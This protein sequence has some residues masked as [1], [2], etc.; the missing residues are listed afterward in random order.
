MTK[1]Q[2]DSE[3]GNPRHPSQRHPD[4]GGHPPVQPGQRGRRGRCAGRFVP[5]SVGGHPLLESEPPPDDRAAAVFRFSPGA[6]LPEVRCGPSPARRVG[7]GRRPK[8]GRGPSAGRVRHGVAVEVL[9]GR[10]DRIGR[11]RPECPRTRHGGTSDAWGAGPGEDR[12]CRPGG[13]SE[14]GRKNRTATNFS[15]HQLRLSEDSRAFETTSVK[16]KIALR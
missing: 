13:R 9:P 6:H 11:T 16:S 7:A 5:G 3:T 10:V 15:P 1:T 4:E 14:G 2:V 12:A 8:A